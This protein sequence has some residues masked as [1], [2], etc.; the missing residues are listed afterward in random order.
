[1]APKGP[2]LYCVSKR[3]GWDG[4]RKWPVLLTFSTVIYADK[5]GGWVDGVQK[6]KKYGDVIH[7]WSLTLNPSGAIFNNYS[8]HIPV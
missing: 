6:G 8:S 5:V 7:V 2:P 3:T 4:S 1:M